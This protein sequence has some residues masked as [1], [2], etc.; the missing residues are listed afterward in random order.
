VTGFD[1][2]VTGWD[3][4]GQPTFTRSVVNAPRAGGAFSPDSTRLALVD[5]SDTVKLY[6][7][8]DLAP[9]A[10]LSVSGP[11]D[12]GP[13]YPATPVAFSPDSR[14]LAVGN[15]LGF[16]RRFDARNGRPLGS[17][18]LAGSPRQLV[19]QL[20]YSPNGRLISASTFEDTLNGAH[21]ID[22]GTGRAYALDPPLPYGFTSA[23]SPDGKQ[24]VATSGAG[25]PPVAYP[26]MND[27]VGHGAPLDTRGF[28]AA[29]AAFSPDG[30]LLALS[31]HDGTLLF[32][33]AVTM[34][35]AGPPLSLTSSI[36]ADITFSP[37]GDL[38]LVQDLKAANHIVD[39]R[40]RA[41]VGDPIPGSSGTPPEFGLN[42]FSTDGKTML[43]PSPQGARLW[44]LDPPDWVRDAC[45][46]AGRNLTHEEWH[47]YFSAFGAYHTTCP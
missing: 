14:E 7:W 32:F 36:L 20:K 46:L 9:I 40:E 33:D 30:S 41:R 4:T 34:R 8:P 29:G 38:L 12:R 37:H 6:G 26:V 42:S 19:D 39:V 15:R 13:L 21:V 35:P 3:L 31:G 10:S 17:P 18:I 27:T 25:F 44:D 1:G 24:L 45:T 43:L 16:V 5:N 2:T 47:H 11:G 28:R 22:I 23:F